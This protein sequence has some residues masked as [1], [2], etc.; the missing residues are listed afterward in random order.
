MI[1]PIR[2]NS[3]I[4]FL[5]FCCCCCHV[6]K[7]C[8]QCQSHLIR[9]GLVVVSV[10]SL[11][12]GLYC[13]NVIQCDTTSPSVKLQVMSA[14]CKVS[15]GRLRPHF[16]S[17]CQPQ[18]STSCQSWERPEYVMNFT[19]SGNPQLFPDPVEME[20]RLV[21]AR[22]SFLSGHASLSWY[23][24]V[25]SAGYL[26]INS[27]SGERNLQTLPVLLIQVRMEAISV[28]VLQKSLHCQSCVVESDSICFNTKLRTRRPLS[29]SLSCNIY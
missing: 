9:S 25:F 17:V 5:V 18:P 15:A 14:V 21:E 27:S 19:C 6:L 8:N 20:D 12:R 10:C 22:L 4:Q 11:L 13:C 28:F 26:H 1:L 23:G 29:L 7:P 3:A 16:M 24:M 2:Y